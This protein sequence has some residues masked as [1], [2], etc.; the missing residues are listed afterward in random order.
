MGLR[1]SIEHA[2]WLAHIL[3]PT[4]TSPN[5]E[6]NEEVGTLYSFIESFRSNFYASRPESIAMASM[7]QETY[8][9]LDSGAGVRA[10]QLLRQ[11]V[12]DLSGVRTTDTDLGS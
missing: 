7:L 6:R 2:N 10:L 12:G 11:Y 1:F 5:M 8:S 4:G 3:Q 9:S